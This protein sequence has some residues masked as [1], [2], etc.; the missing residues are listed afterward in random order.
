MPLT[1]HPI[2]AR[3]IRLMAL[4]VAAL[5]LTVVGTPALAAEA[6]GSGKSWGGFMGRLHIVVLH[7]PIGLLIGAFA[8]EVLGFFK[9]SK[10]F[11]VAAAWLFVLGAVSS[12][13][14]VISGLLLATET[15]GTGQNAF[16]ILWAG[17]EGGVG[18]T[19]GWHMWLGVVLMFAAIAAA[20]LK[21]MAVKRQWVED[22]AV[23]ARGGWPLS[24]ARL[25][26]LFSMLL[27]PV[28]GHLGGNM[29]HTRYYLFERSPI[30]FPQWVID[31]PAEE[32][33][34]NGEDNGTPDG[35]V[36]GPVADWNANI[37][38]AMD[39]HC[40]AC[41]GADS[42]KGKLRLDTLEAAMKGG[43]V[44][45]SIE[46]GEA[47]YSELYVRVSL[48]VTHDEYMP[49]AK[50]IEKHGQFTAEQVAYLG[51]WI[52]AWD[53]K[54]KD[55]V[56]AVKPDD[57]KNGGS[58]PPKPKPLIDP[59]ALKA[60]TGAGGNAQ[61]LSQEEDPGLLTIKFAYLKDLDPAAVAK[62]EPSA[63]AVAWMTFE[64]SGFGDEAAKALPVMPK[65]TRLNLKD[66]KVTDAGLGLLPEMPAIEWLNLFGTT[67]TDKGLEALKR[68]TTLDKLYLTGTQ[69]T[70]EG[71]DA[72]RKAL[73]DTQVFSDHD[74]QFQFKP[75]APETT[76]D[77]PD[78][79][80]AK[81]VNDKC[82]VSGAPVKPG[83]VSTFNNKTVGFCC[84][85]CKGKFDAEPAKF[86]AKLPK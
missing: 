79:A 49:P 56:A 2:K 71:V 52:Q 53:G 78:P 85:N 5:L 75:A 62:L 33:G 12:V 25:A 66:T 82:P 15:T 22:S 77:K 64:G 36:L 38:P 23:P 46:A 54:L 29:V 8:I 27:L 3:L 70:A 44:G 69:V 74:G 6:G 31:F 80:A 17:D 39:K 18:E 13:P 73:P 60:I 67:V 81:P 72:L 11:D 45:P 10:G 48:P 76:E 34:G 21:V 51:E 1:H 61:S 84:N 43:T 32:G 59:A 16:S 57:P 50:K 40:I 55:P 37:Q 26:L 30:N 41:H 63:D 86:A 58:E 65:I 19:L 47:R 4:F 7:L 68:Y 42:Q 9:R 24:V 28:A 35:P 83:F 14:A 20:V